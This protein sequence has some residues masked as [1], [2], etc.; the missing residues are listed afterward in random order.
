MPVSCFADGLR[1]PDEKQ[2]PTSS[3]KID[4]HTKWHLLSVNERFMAPSLGRLQSSLVL[5]SRIGIALIM[6]YLRGLKFWEG[7]NTSA[8]AVT[9]NYAGELR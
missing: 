6:F 3:Y 7:G 4:I 1:A 8:I 2:K 5:G 9:A